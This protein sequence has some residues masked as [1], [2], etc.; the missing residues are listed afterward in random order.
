MKP[1]LRWLR[2]RAV[3]LLII[4]FVW[5]ARPTPRLL[6]AGATISLVGLA[7]RSWAAGHIRKE[8]ELTTHGPYAHTRNPLYVGS[9]FLGLGVT[10]AGGRWVFVVL[11]L[12]FFLLVYGRTI[13]GEARLLEDLYGERY[14]HYAAH[15]PLVLPRLT[16]YRPPDDDERASFTLRRYRKNREWEALLGT[17]AGFA[18]LVGKMLWTG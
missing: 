2:L 14:R 10:V 8:R 3:W 16:A 7:A 17:L 15:V 13:G 18:V 1:D 5:Y 12:L 9:F 4:P 11:F 6:A